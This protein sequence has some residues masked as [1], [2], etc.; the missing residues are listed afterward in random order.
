MGESQQQSKA[1]YQRG[2]QVMKREEKQ[3]D[4]VKHD[5]KATD[6]ALIQHLRKQHE[7]NNN[8]QGASRIN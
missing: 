2:S 1:Q 5:E 6:L 8:T 4:I 3:K 7:E